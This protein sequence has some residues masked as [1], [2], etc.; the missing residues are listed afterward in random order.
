MTM[1]PH[2]TTDRERVGNMQPELHTSY[3]ANE[4]IVRQMFSRPKVALRRITDPVLRRL[5]T[6][7]DRNR[8]SEAGPKA[9]GW[10]ENYL[11]GL[12]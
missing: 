7:Y 8:R 6:A 4:K 10:V 5:V 9:R 11:R 1:Q 2:A 12:Q 3:T